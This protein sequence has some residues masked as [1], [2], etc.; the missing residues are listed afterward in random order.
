MLLFVRILRRS[1]AS[2]TKFQDLSLAHLGWEHNKPARG[3]RQPLTSYKHLLRLRP[4]A[5]SIY[6][7]GIVYGLPPKRSIHAGGTTVIVLR[8]AAQISVDGPRGQ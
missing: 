8:L 4:A 2:L 3:P 1:A 5:T 6:T 7:G